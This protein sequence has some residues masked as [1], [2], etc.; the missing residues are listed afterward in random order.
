MFYWFADQQKG[1]G[2]KIIKKINNNRFASVHLIAVKNDNKV[3]SN[4]NQKRM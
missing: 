2:P 3:K 1:L 4:V